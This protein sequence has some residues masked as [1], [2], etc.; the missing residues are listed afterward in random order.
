MSPHTK[1]TGASSEGDDSATACCD[2]WSDRSGVDPRGVKRED[3]EKYDS[4]SSVVISAC[5]PRLTII[6]MNPFSCSI[7]NESIRVPDGLTN[8]E[9]HI[10]TKR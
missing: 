2:Y 6:R 1:D 4:V 7:L 3:K 8:L 10:S 9:Y 5:T